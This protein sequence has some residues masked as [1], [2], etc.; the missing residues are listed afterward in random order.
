MKPVLS[1]PGPVH[2]RASRKAAGL[3]RA[4]RE[5]RPSCAAACVGKGPA[6]LSV[7]LCG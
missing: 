2:H 1:L 6:I 3:L 7:D 5:A 4:R